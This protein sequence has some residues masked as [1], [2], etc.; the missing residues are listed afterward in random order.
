MFQNI[1]ISLPLRMISPRII[2]TF[3]RKIALPS[4]SVAA[5]FGL[6]WDSFKTVGLAYFFLSLFFHYFIYDTMFSKEYNF[7][8]NLGLDKRALW[9]STV[10]IGA[11]IFII[12]SFL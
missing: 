7:Y 12:S 5:V 3:Q 10:V 6:L 11:V 8:Y 2:L 1:I 9:I 4:I